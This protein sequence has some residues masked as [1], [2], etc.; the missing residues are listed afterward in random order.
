[1][2]F[3]ILYEDEHIIVCYKPAGIP[4][5]TSKVSAMDSFDLDMAD[6]AMKELEEYVLPEELQDSMER[7]RALVADVAMEEVMNLTDDMAKLLQEL[8]E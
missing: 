2:N 5:Q 4:T 6:A 7:L 3:R 1:M 8:E